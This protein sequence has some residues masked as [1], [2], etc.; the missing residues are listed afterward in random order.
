MIGISPSGAIR[1]VSKPVSGSVSDRQTWQSGILELLDAE[2]S[3]MED[4]GI[5][6]AEYL[7]SLGVW[8]NI[9]L[10]LRVKQQCSGVVTSAFGTMWFPEGR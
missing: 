4:T 7:I 5:D 1:F 2:D 10:L 8:L 6:T 9:P 3:V